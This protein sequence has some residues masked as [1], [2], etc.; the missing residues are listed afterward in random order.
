MINVNNVSEINMKQNHSLTKNRQTQTN[1]RS[2]TRQ[3]IESHFIT[4]LFQSSYRL[5][6]RHQPMLHIISVRNDGNT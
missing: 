6:Y 5:I 2:K 3:R 4:H 1:H